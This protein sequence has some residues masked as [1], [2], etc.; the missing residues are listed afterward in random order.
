MD[1]MEEFIS[2]E[3]DG[4]RKGERRK[5]REEWEGKEGRK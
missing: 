4:G 5:G 3:R 2:D 1:R